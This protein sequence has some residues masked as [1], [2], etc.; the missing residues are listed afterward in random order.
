MNLYKFVE[1]KMR[2]SKQIKLPEFGP[3]GQRKLGNASLLVIGAGGLGCPVLMYL[4]SA[5]I[6][7]L[8]VMDFD[9]VEESNLPRQ[10]LYTTDD[11]GTLKAECAAIRLKEMNPLVDIVVYP[12]RLTPETAAG[13][14]GNYDIIA[15]CTDNFT[16][17]YL[18]NDTCIHLDKPWVFASIE[19]WQ[20]Q[21][22][23][24]NLAI[25]GVQGP[26]YRCL[27]PE[28]PIDGPN[29]DDI[30][31][32]GSIAAVTAS[33]QANEII[34]SIVGAGKVLSGKLWVA[35]VL[36]NEFT[37]VEF[38]R[39]EKAIKLLTEKEVK[40]EKLQHAMDVAIND[41]ISNSSNYILIDIRERHEYENEPSEGE[42][43]PFDELM[44]SLGRFN[45]PKRYMLL[46]KEGRK[47][48][49]LAYHLKE[50]YDINNVYSLQ[51]GWEKLK[52][53]VKM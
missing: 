49:F 40:K 43:I 38:K 10:P 21:V 9:V 53:V 13:I 42:N 24:F 8:G 23:V 6:G 15:D 16:T 3:E 5:G 25:N 22:S 28:S 31:I 26:S 32:I 4:V 51:G 47:S 46:C 2:Y 45:V 44:K 36:N 11:I 37:Y 20:G 7:K 39:N 12:Q 48:L 33:M 19:G 18:I 52:N 41:F 34:K 30:G 1:K 14:F 35:D 50:K 17:R 27:Y 29:C